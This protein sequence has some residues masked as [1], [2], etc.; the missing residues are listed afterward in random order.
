MFIYKVEVFV[1]WYEYQDG[2]DIYLFSV[3]ASNKK[4]LWQLIDAYVD[5]HDLGYVV[6][7]K[8][9]EMDHAEPAVITCEKQ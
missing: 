5:S 6:D 7:H 9:V 3:M 8:I 2:S 1:K 4:E